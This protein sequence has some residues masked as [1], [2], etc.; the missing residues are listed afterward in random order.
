MKAIDICMYIDWVKLFD[1]LGSVGINNGY[2][3]SA[4]YLS[5][6]EKSRASM[7][8]V[9]RLYCSFNVS[10]CIYL[11]CFIPFQVRF[12]SDNIHCSG[13]GVCCVH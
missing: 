2:F 8:P 10:V 11:T 4:W 13:S 9:V 12:R 3:S 1:V 5:G 6:K 7:A